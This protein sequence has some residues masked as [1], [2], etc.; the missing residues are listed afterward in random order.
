[1]EEVLQ[2]IV[3]IGG[4]GFLNYQIIVRVRDIDWGDEQDKKYLLYFLSSFDY[5]LFLVFDYFLPNLIFSIPLSILTALGAS[6]VFPDFMIGFYRFIN[7]IRKDNGLPS[8]EF[9][10]MY[11][12]FANDTG[13]QNCFVFQLGNKQVVS[14]GYIAYTNGENDDLSLILSPYISVNDPEKYRITDEDSLLEY[15]DEE[16]IQAKI[17]LNLEKQIKFIYF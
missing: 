14:S 15:L 8:A 17:Y 6:I 11:D 10:T 16:K 3:A 13:C 5:C 7:W 2:S 12:I 1:M 9:Q 4:F